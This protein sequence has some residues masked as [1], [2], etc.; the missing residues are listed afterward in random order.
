MKHCILYRSDRSQES[1]QEYLAA[2]EHF[3]GEC[4]SHRTAIYD[5]TVIGRY[6]VLPHYIETNL[7]ISINDSWLV[8]TPTQ[9][10]WVADFEYYDVLQKYTPKTYT[11]SQARDIPQGSFVVKGQTNSKKW[12][13][14][15]S[16]FAKSRD[17][18]LFKAY[19][20]MDDS[21]IGCQDILIREYVPL[22]THE[23]GI[24]GLPFTE[25]W[26]F[27]YLYGKYVAHGYYWSTASEELIAQKKQ[28][29]IEPE[30]K[31]FAESMAKLVSE[32]VIF[33]AIDIAKTVE[34][35]WIVIELNDG[36]MSGLSEIDPAAFYKNMATICEEVEALKM[37]TFT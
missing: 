5:R 22:V 26:R 23:I 29:D 30:G 35:N 24:N 11:L 13:W 7:D 2:R 6:S 1:T 27:F 18:A 14:D 33:V 19:C 9:H 25:E 34:G 21:M 28:E 31:A 20:L 4:H 15:R 17:E 3:P 16:M 8:N 36:Q 32:H 37:E 12:Q 10:R